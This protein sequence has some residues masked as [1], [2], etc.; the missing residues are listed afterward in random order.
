MRSMRCEC[1]G[2]KENE[3]GYCGCDSYVV[4]TE[5]GKC[6]SVVLDYEQEELTKKS[7]RPAKIVYSS[8]P[9]AEQT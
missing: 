1:L 4:I 7:L 9:T 5:D 8:A 6:D 3:G 2:C